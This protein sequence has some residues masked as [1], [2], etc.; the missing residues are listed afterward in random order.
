MPNFENF[1]YLRFSSVNFS[2]NLQNVT[3]CVYN[4]CNLVKFTQ[5]VQNNVWMFIAI[6]CKGG[7]DWSTCPRV[8]TLKIGERMTLV[9]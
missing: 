9:L 1:R 7:F 3:W 4:I 6:I 2:P 8:T 5:F